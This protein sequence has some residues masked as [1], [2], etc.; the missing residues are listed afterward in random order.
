MFVPN[1]FKSIIRK[2]FR[3]ICCVWIFCATLL[4]FT[5]V[6]PPRWWSQPKSCPKSPRRA[7]RLATLEPLRETPMTMKKTP[8]TRKCRQKLLQ[9]ARG[10]RSTYI[11][12][13]WHPNCDPSMPS[14]GPDQWP[15]HK[16]MHGP[17]TSAPH[18]LHGCHALVWNRV[19]RGCIQR[20]WWP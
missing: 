16:C 13:A 1:I 4:T 7:H 19:K 14:R 8:E 15:C 17:C 6:D 5:T 2:S 11:G 20:A 18:A 10:D 9:N 3:N 12:T